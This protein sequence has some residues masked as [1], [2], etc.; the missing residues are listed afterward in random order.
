MKRLV[1]L[2]GGPSALLV[3]MLAASP[4]LAQGLSKAAA[5]AQSK[6]TVRVRILDNCVLT[7]TKPGVDGGA[8]PQCRCFASA[9]S[10]AMKPDEAAAYDGKMPA[11]LDA[12]AEK[13]WA[14]CNKK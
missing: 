11:R 4:V 1:R 2:S 10:K 6:N 5:P 8:A 3:L 9:V 14:T 13:T 7:Q 12:M